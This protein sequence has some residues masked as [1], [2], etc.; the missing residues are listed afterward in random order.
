MNIAEMTAW[1]AVFLFSVTCHEAAH[2]WMAMKNGDLTAYSGG[3]VSLDPLPHI[4]REPVGMVVLPIISLL[5]IHWPF[6]YASAPYDPHWAA[7]HYRR[8][9]VM[10]LA[11]PAANLLLM[12]GAVGLTWLGILGGLFI[13]PE[14]VNFTH[15]VTPA[16]PGAA[17][18]L[19]LLLSILF[20]MNLILVILNMLPLPPLDGSEAITLFM[21][22]EQADKYKRIINN[23]SFALI[24]LLIAWQILSPLFDYIFTA[25]V[26]LIYPGYYS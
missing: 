19:A 22:S 26:S 15:I 2:A 14:S 5:L 7:R 8:A 24:G 20:S 21:N 25:L 13:L 1:Y 23:P 10:A 17:P 3:Q 12:I 11:G 9:A 6:G 18:P 16:G 4:R